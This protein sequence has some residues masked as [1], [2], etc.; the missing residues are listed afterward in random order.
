MPLSLIRAGMKFA[1]L[2]PWKPPSTW[3]GL[4]KKGLSFDIKHLKREDMDELV[5]ALQDSVI[6]IDNEKELIKI[7]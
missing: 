2:M 1:T 7:Y 6:N 3:T 4:L 5:S